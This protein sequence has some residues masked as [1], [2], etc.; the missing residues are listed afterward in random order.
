MFENE[1]EI[2]AHIVDA[3]EPANDNSGREK[4]A[5]NLDLLAAAKMFNINVIVC[6]EIYDE[7]ENFS[8]YRWQIYHPGIN[9]SVIF[10]KLT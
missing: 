6:E 4:W 2:L 3:K 7:E 1:N 10:Y 5:N 8:G 9:R